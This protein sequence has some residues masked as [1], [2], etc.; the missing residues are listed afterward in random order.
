[1]ADNNTNEVTAEQ[2]AQAVFEDGGN[3]IVDLSGIEEMKF[4]VLPKGIYQAKIDDVQYGAS[5]TSGNKM[6]TFIFAV[7]GGDYSGRKLYT[8]ASFSPKALKGTKTLL[9]RI[10]AEMFAGQFNPQ[11]IVDSGKLL[12]RQV[13]LKVDIQERKDNGEDQNRVQVMPPNAGASSG[14]AGGDGFFK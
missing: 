3:L 6:F 14:A 11:E 9:N 5:K 8:Y 13:T 1:M 7:D 4:E 2:Y 10:D 12:G